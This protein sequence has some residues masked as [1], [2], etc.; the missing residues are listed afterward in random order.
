M[1]TP[2]KRDRGRMVLIGLLALS[3]LGNALSI[4]AV[5]KLRSLRSEL[6]G[7]V[8]AP[9]VFPRAE[10]RAL[11]D[12]I[13]QN[14]DQV[15]P[16]FQAL[17]AARAAVVEAGTARPFDRATLDAAMAQFGTRIDETLGVLQ[18]II[19]DTLQATAD[20]DLARPD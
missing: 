5:A 4:G 16:A 1:D 8:I 13:R 15:Q 17:I 10:R 18:P 14:A 12:A 9:P 3:L 20:G 2:M 19:A 11:R 6:A 7:S